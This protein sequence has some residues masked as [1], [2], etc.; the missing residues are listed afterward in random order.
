MKRKTLLLVLAILLNSSF[1]INNCVSQWVQIYSGT[2]G[3]YDI[4]FITQNIG[5]TAG[6]NGRIYKTTDGGY[7]WLNQSI[8]LNIE[9]NNSYFIN[10]NTGLIFGGKCSAYKTTNGGNNWILKYTDTSSSQLYFIAN[11]FVNS[12]TGY[13]VGDRII[14]T[15]NGGETWMNQSFPL[16]TTKDY[17]SVT[18]IN[19]IT[20]WSVGQHN[21]NGIVIHTTNGGINWFQQSLIDSLNLEYIKFFDLNTGI[22][23]GNGSSS[24]N[25]TKIYKTINGG[26]NWVLQSSIDSSMVYSAFFINLNTG[27]VASNKI[28][29]TSN[30]GVNWNYQT[31]VASTYGLFFMNNY[32][33]W[34]TNGS[35]VYKTTNGGSVFVHNI[36]TE[37]PY[38]YSISQNYPN[39]FN[40]STNIKFDVVKLSDVKIVVYDVQGR[41]VQ[42][43]VN[44][45]LKPGTYETTFDGSMLNSGVYF[46]KILTGEF[47]ETRRMLLIK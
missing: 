14:K 44:E 8:G 29:R 9:L 19:E 40:P 22:I 41:E 13:V 11:H 38:S 34:C 43:L 7:S 47:S 21:T 15:T 4:N 26:L 6:G 25:P 37:I 12:M 42:T 45:S 31:S 28:Y 46:Y 1:F 18:F 3:N 5:W 27:W 16:T 35:I 17:R 10:E 36:S 33:G 39:P 20:G 2:V 24:F 32:T 30:G 23:I